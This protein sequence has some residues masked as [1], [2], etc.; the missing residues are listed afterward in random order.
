MTSEKSEP[1]KKGKLSFWKKSFWASGAGASTIMANSHGYLAMP[2]YQ[3]ALGL[4]PVLLG[5]A[6]GVP[7]FVDAITDPIMGYISDNT[8]SRF[9]RRRPY[10]FIGGILSALMFFFMWSPPTFLGTGGIALYFLLI[11]ILYYIAYTIFF[12]PWGA[13]GFE[14]TTDYNERTSVQAY[15]MFLQAVFGLS[16]GF[17]WKISMMFGKNEIEGVK[18]V[19]IVFGLV[20]LVTSIMPAIT[21]REKISVQAQEKI[22]F[23][24]SIKETVK[25][26]PFMKLCLVTLLMFLG[27]FLVNP[28]AAYINI[29]YVFGP[30]NQSIKIQS[31]EKLRSVIIAQG[32][33]KI[34]DAAITQRSG[35]II[36]ADTFAKAN[37]LINEFG[38]ERLEM[39]DFELVPQDLNKISKGFTQED[40]RETTENVITKNLKNNFSFYAVKKLVSDEQ[41][42]QFLSR[43]RELSGRGLSDIEAD[44]RSMIGQSTQLIKVIETAETSKLSDI[45]TEYGDGTLDGLMT[46]AA[47]VVS[48]DEVSTFNIWGNIAFQA[49]MLLTIPSVTWLSS[50]FGKKVIYIVG[51][52]IIMLGFLSSWFTYSPTIP[53]LQCITLASLGAGLAVIFTLGQSMVAD[54]C[55]V[56]ELNTGRRREGMF[57]AIFA[58]TIKAGIAGTLVLSGFMLTMTGYSSSAIFRFQ[59]QD[60]TESMRLLYMICPA[61]AAAAS[62]I[63]I[64]TTPISHKQMEQVR[65]QLEERKAVK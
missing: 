42:E 5:I 22:S 13:L 49:C 54:I 33:D 62:I 48:K 65:A 44:L 23:V 50:K 10:I 32:S 36:K 19:G 25:N 46:T 39:Q 17:M 45:R 52:I 43:V 31:I 41:V 3:I 16:L 38:F 58:W 8:H 30:Q 15:N 24:H 37:I 12:I 59:V 21:G 55:D 20:V 56:D 7:R 29:N 18:V 61:I 6:M 27:I 9:G 2:I 63:I 57:N 53:Y 51:L 14:L 64:I 11:S 35:E 34:V 40:L 47:Y 26:G 4:D 28:F 60:I 1:Q